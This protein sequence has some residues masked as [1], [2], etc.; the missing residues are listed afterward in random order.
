MNEYLFLW[1]IA[2]VL[3][4]GA[5]SPGPSFFIVAQN[6]LSKSRAH[7]VATALG[8]GLGVSVFAI[9]ASFGVTALLEN[10]PSAYLAFKLLGGA[11]LLYLAY[12]IWRGASQPLKMANGHGEQ[13]SEDSSSQGE[14]LFKAFLTGLA[15]QISNPKT[16]LVIAGIFAAFV[17]AQPPANTAVL[18]ALIAFVIDFS[19]YAIVAI[20]LSTKAT[21]NL[22][23]KAKTGFDRTAAIFLGVVGIK[24]LVA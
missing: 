18:V 10:V 5:M 2:G 19:W 23:N 6:S 13:S 11:Y 20:S 24:L 12:K 7:G 9:L 1:A 22:Y 15:T 16:A 17:P 4:V 21:R 14:G 3:F 8:T